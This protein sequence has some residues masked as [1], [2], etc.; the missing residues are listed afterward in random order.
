MNTTGTAK[1]G[2]LI[3]AALVAIPIFLI[4]AIVSTDTPPNFSANL[5]PWSG[6]ALRPDAPIP[7][8]YVTWVN[9]SGK[10]C[11]EIT[12]AFIAA[13]IDVE[14]RWRP[15]A[16]ATNPASAGGNARGLAQFQDAAWKTWG[17]DY[18]NDGTSSPLDPE[19][20]IIA[21]GKL[22]CSNASWAAQQIE[23]GNIQG[24]IIEVALAA[25]FCGRGCVSDNRGVP[26]SGK[27]ND[28]PK[29]VLSRV[30]KYAATP[31]FIAGGWTF[32]LPAGKYKVGSPFGPRG[33]RLHAG[34]DLTAA[35]NTPIYAAAAGKVIVVICDSGNGNCNID[36]GTGVGGCGWYVEIQHKGN[37]ITRYCHMQRR[38]DVRVGQQVQA[39][40]PIGI[41]GSSGN[42]SGPHLHF[43]VHTS[44]PANNGNATNPIA[45]LRKAGIE[46]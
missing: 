28:Y 4:G 5:S 17:G 20:A 3:T 21:L 27:A 16:E 36:G 45:F 22:M 12:P 8:S 41:V 42:S 18:D 44:S 26:P 38:P 9:R 46:P 37:I 34:V 6:G 32:P 43:E 10:L 23:D 2:F 13:Q 25:Y 35:K 39:G 29:L 31:N 24:D 15:D 7:A 30:S 33:G 1:T 14:S 11:D 40:Q 19:D